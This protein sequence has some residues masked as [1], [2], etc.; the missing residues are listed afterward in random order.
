MAFKSLHLKQKV[1]FFF[2]MNVKTRKFDKL[3]KIII[4]P[5]YFLITYQNHLNI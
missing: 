3:I 4:F 2:K 1:D 5:N